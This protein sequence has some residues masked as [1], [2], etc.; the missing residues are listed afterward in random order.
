MALAMALVMAL[1]LEK[2]MSCALDLEK[3]NDYHHGVMTDTE[4]FAVG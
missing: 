1:G 2:A 4:I 3:D